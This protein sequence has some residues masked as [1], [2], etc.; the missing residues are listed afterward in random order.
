MWLRQAGY[1]LSHIFFPRICEG[2]QTPLIKTEQVLCLH[3]LEKLPLTCHYNQPDNEAAMRFAGRFPFHVAVSFTYF[4]SHGLVQHLLHGLKYRGKKDV[5][6]FLGRQFALALQQTAWIHTVDLILPVPLHKKKEAARGY[7]QSVLIAEG[8][9][10]VLQIPYSAKM[11]LRI[12]QTESQTLKTRKERA[13]NME[14][15][16]TTHASLQGKHVLLLDDV[17]TTGATLEACAQ[18]VLQQKN[19]RVSLATIGLAL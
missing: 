17:L 4:I 11:L 16:F 9:H 10:S 15:A 8:M 2:C 1:G 18:T 3:C 13:E 19:V 6:R 14:G 5:G 7:N 12:K